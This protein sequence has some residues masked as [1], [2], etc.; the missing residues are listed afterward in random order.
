MKAVLGQAAVLFL[1]QNFVTTSVG[2]PVV[3]LRLGVLVWLV[4]AVEL[5]ACF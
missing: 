3:T 1:V 5:P 4:S 2:A